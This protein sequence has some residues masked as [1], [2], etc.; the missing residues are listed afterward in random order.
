MTDSIRIDS[1]EKRVAINDDPARVIVFNPSSVLF[2]ERFYQLNSELQVK[3][4]EY[5]Q[6]SAELEQDP[7]LDGNGMPANTGKRLELLREACEY[8]RGRI[9]ELFGA[10]TSQ[11]AFGDA[12][13][14][15]MFLQ[16]LEGIAPFIRTERTAKIQK[17]VSP[18]K[19]K[20]PKHR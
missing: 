3:L 13:S 14:P 16:F 9:D 5:Q 4:E 11:T 1:G 2:V 17:Y 19:P 6:R 7:A 12:L 8:I 18:A 10:G 20:R 15:E